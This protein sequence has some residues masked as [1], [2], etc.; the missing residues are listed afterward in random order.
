MCIRDRRGTFTEK[1]LL[2]IA[3]R[4]ALS[5]DGIDFLRQQ[6]IN[7][8]LHESCP[9]VERAALPL[10]G[11]TWV[12]TGN[13]AHFSRNE[14]TERLRAL[15][16]TVTGS[17]SKNTTTVIAGPGAGAKEKEAAT[18]GVPVRGEDYLISVLK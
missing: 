13:L 15:G 11:Q 1:A 5:N 4:D 18:L 17:V 16:A 2:K 6:W 9:K 12:L 10:E 3:K 7:W 8:G 14:A